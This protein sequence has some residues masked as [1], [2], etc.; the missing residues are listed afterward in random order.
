MDLSDESF[1]SL[2]HA[3]VVG[4]GVSA[5]QSDNLARRMGS[6]PVLNTRWSNG[7]RYPAE[8]DFPSLPGASSLNNVVSASSAPVNGARK[9]Q[10]QL[11]GKKVARDPMEDFPSLGDPAKN[12]SSLYQVPQSQTAASWTKAAAPKVSA[13]VGNP[14]PEVTVKKKEGMMTTLKKQERQQRPP[15]MVDEDDFPGLEAVSKGNDTSKSSGVTKKNQKKSQKKR[16]SSSIKEEI[17][18]HQQKSTTLK[19]ERN[20]TLADK[21]VSGSTTN[22]DSLSVTSEGI[23]LNVVN[24][25]N[26]S[27]DT[28]DNEWQEIKPAK[29]SK[30]LASA[31]PEQS[32]SL[33]RPSIPGLSFSQGSSNRAA[34]MINLPKELPKTQ[35]IKNNEED[36]PSLAPSTKM[37]VHFRPALAKGETRA[38]DREGSA[39][40]VSVRSK[41]STSHPPGFAPSAVKAPP[42]G[43]KAK[44]QR[45]KKEKIPAI[46]QQSPDFS[47][48]N[49]KLLSTVVEMLGGKSLEF[50]Q[51]KTASGQF[52]RGEM[53]SQDY[54][55]QCLNILDERCFLK[56]LPELIV[57]LPDINKQQVSSL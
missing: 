46:Y 48:R 36:F 50:S 42:P 30:G 12:L 25:V 11:K 31:M 19:S 22:R 8:E 20:P 26:K 16:P 17:E 9:K 54:Y 6:Q 52:R 45:S 32:V 24:E 49:S 7:H 3:S 29:P 1:P 13:Q 35:V 53:N 10:P 14:R 40:S 21:L 18:E 23:G 51:F 55:Q 57:L 27:G 34:G 43:F 56:I 33:N 44:V 47:A 41:T 15:T 5:G 38:N 2:G 37:N 4:A 28:D 39:W